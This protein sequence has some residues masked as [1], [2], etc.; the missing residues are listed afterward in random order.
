VTKL[1]GQGAALP[2]RSTRPGHADEHSAALWVTHRQA[3]FVRSPVESRHI[4]PGCLL[5]QGDEITQRRQSQVVAFRQL[6]H[7]TT[8]MIRDNV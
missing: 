1:P 3:V 5:D 8:A 7:A 6:R 4:T 2:H